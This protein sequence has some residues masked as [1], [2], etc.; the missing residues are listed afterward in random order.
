MAPLSAGTRCGV[1]TRETATRVSWFVAVGG[2]LGAAADL[3]VV[4]VPHG[5]VIPDFGR[6]QDGPQDDALPVGGADVQLGV[7]ENSHRG[8]GSSKAPLPVF[9][10]KLDDSTAAVDQVGG[11]RLTRV[12]MAHSAV[13][14][15]ALKSVRTKR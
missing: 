8:L 12:T 15:A 6:Q 1:E 11:V 13:S 7:G 3:A 5:L 14:C 9:R 10:V 2:A 4:D